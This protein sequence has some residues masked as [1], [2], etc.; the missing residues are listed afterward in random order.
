M[1]AIMEPRSSQHPPALDP[2]S[3]IDGL[4]DA[5]ERQS[6]AAAAIVRENDPQAWLFMER[7][8]YVATGHCDPYAEQMLRRGGFLPAL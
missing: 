4:I 5:V 8:R 2:E 3:G 1:T 6:A 7:A